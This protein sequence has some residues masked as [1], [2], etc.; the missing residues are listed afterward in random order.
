MKNFGP[1]M[2]RDAVEDA[3][4]EGC[5]MKTG[6]VGGEG[7]KEG[8]GSFPGRAS[9]VG[10]LES[11]QDDIDGGRGSSRGGNVAAPTQMLGEAVLG[12]NKW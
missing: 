1:K 5:W 9:R 12:S 6:G 3:P 10:G 4:A 8:D 11:G 2:V 7:G